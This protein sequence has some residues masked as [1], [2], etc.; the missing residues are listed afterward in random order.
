VRDRDGRRDLSV[1]FYTG[2][3]LFF[4]SIRPSV[5]SEL[6]LCRAFMVDPDGV[7]VLHKHRWE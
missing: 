5:L 2:I 1:S 3:I 4:I 6:F 7:V